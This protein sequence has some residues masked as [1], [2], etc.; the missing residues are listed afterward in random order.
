MIHF[1]VFSNACQPKMVFLFKPD[2]RFFTLNLL[3]EL[4]EFFVA[5]VS[6]SKTG[7]VAITATVEGIG[8]GALLDT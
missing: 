7:P 6:I 5:S 2:D 8:I 1:M 3:G 4:Y